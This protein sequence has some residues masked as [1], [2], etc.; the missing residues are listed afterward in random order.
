[1]G[2]A[3]VAAAHVSF[4]EYHAL[5]DWRHVE[6]SGRSVGWIVDWACI[7]KGTEM[8]VDMKG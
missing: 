1:M 7:V 8:I 2:H 3:S 4:Q 6:Q 5:D